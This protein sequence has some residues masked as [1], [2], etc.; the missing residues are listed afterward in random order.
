MQFSKLVFPAPFGPMIPVIEPS[1]TDRSTTER[2]ASP[3]KES[4]R[5][6]TDR[7]SRLSLSTTGDPVMRSFHEEPEDRES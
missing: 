3:P 7:M 5:P 6:S 2:A 1:R 4:D